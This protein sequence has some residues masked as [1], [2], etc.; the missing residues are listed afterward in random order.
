MRRI[1]L[2]LRYFWTVV[3][4]AILASPSLWAIG[5]IHVGASDGHVSWSPDW[6]DGLHDLITSGGCIYGHW[7]NS[8]NEFFYRGST[9]AFNEF[10]AGYARLEHTPLRL[11]LHAASHRRT[12]VGIPQARDPLPYRDASGRRT[13]ATSAQVTCGTGH[14][15]HSETEWTGIEP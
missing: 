13:A 10:L 15:E 7:V 6:P 14:W 8:G 3:L 1:R 2:A 12:G 4:A 9:D 11:T 5:G